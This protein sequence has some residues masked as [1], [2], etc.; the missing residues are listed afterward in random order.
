MVVGM[1]LVLTVLASLYPAWRASLF[2]PV[3][4]LRRG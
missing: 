3:E 1:A 2:H 4:L